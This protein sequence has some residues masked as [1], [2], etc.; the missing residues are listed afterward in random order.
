MTEARGG[1]VAEPEQDAPEGVELRKDG[2][3]VLTLGEQKV[4]LRRPLIGEFK[5]F[6]ELLH[7]TQDRLNEGVGRT[8][9]QKRKEL[10][11]AHTDEDEEAVEALIREVTA[12]DRQWTEANESSSL[13]LLRTAVEMLGDHP[14]AAADE[15]PLWAMDGMTV[16][17]LIEHWRFN[18][19]A[20]GPG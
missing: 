1:D 14:L 6:R 7:A 12:I 2:T 5:K 13:E 10:K 16:N 20:L 18:P 17:R 11:Q 4:T 3:I 8:L 19:L 15:L 9:T